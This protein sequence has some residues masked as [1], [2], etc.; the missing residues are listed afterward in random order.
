MGFKG[1]IALENSAGIGHFIGLQSEPSRSKT[2]WA[3]IEKDSI[4]ARI[5]AKLYPEANVQHSP[6]ET[7]R[8]PN[9]SVDLVIGNF[10][11]AKE[12][13]SDERYPKLSLHN[14]F[15][16][17]SLD[18]VKPG[19]IVAAITSNSTMDNA[20][21]A[22]ARQYMA[23]RADLIGAIRL[24]NNA[25]KENANTDVTTDILF[26][27]KRDGTPFEG[28]PFTRTVEGRT[29]DDEPI[30]LNEYFQKHPEMMLGKMSLEGTMYGPDQPA[31]VPIEGADLS[32]QIQEAITKLPNDAFGAQQLPGEAAPVG[33][34]PAL[35]KVGTLS[36]RGEKPG[37]IQP[38]GTSE[39]PEWA[40]KPE[41][42][43][44]AK[45]Y[46][47]IRDMTQKL[48]DKMGTTDAT[49]D[50][51]ATDR[52]ELNRLYDD[53]VSKYGRLNE[54]GS[55]FLDEDGD[56]ALALSL[57][58]GTPK[59]VEGVGKAGK[60]WARRVTDWAKSK[61][62]TQRT[63]FPRSEPTSAET[64]E[65]GYHISMNF[66]GKVD[67][68]YIAQL[69]GKT[70]E[71][72]KQ[73]LVNANLAFENATTGQWEPSWKYLSGDVRGKLAEA[74]RML[75]DNP[76]YAPNVAALEKVQPERIAFENITFRLGATYIPPEVVARFLQEKLGL[77]D[78][79]VQFTKQTGDWHIAASRGLNEAL[80]TTT[81]GIHGI[82]GSEM[83][84]L[85]LNLKNPI[86]YTT[87]R[88]ISETTGKVYD[89]EV[90]DR[91][92]T[93]QAEAKQAL[94]KD[95]FVDWAKQD[96]QA[97]KLI[98]DSYNESADIMRMPTF[99]PPTFEHYPGASEEIKL[100]D[101]QKRVVTR[102]LSDSTI[103]AHAVGTGKTYAMI[104]A[105]MEMRRLGLAKKPMIV[106]QNATLG[107]FAASFKRLYPS[108]RVLVPGERQRDAQNRQ[109]TMSRIATGD[110]DAVI[111]PQSFINMMPDD[112]QRER[113]Y[114]D[115]QI[116][117]LKEALIEEAAE[118]GGKSPKAK[119]IQR[120]IK[121]LQKQLDKLT[122]RAQDN[123]LNFDQLGVDAL[124]VDEA[125]EYK[126]NQFQTRMDKIK[127]LDTGFSQ[128]GLSMMMKLRSVQEKNQGRNTIFATGTPISNTLAE[129]WNMMRFIRPDVLEKYGIEKFDSFAANFCTA[130]TKLEMQP[131]GAW[132]PETRFALFVNGPELISA[133]RTVADVVT[134]EEINLPG[135]PALREGKIQPVN[136]PQTPNVTAYIAQIQDQLNAFK[137]M[138]GKERYEHSYIP[139]VCF[140]NAKKA[141]LD[142][143]LINPDL[144]EEPGNKLSIAADQISKI[145]KDSNDVK[146]AQ[147]VF[148][149]L[150]QNK[151]E[152]GNV[153]FNLYEEMK[154]KLIAL[155]IPENEI[156]IFS[157]KL[158]EAQ[159][160]IAIQ[161]LNDGVYRV[162]IGGTQRMGVGI[163]AQEH[164]IAL[165]HLDAPHRPMDIE[166]RNG[167]IVRQGN[168][169]P[170]VDIFSYGVEKSLDAAL[171]Q[172]L[173]RKQ[174]FTNQIM[175]GDLKGR[176]FE[177]PNNEISMSFDE[178]MAAYSGDPL[179]LEKVT[180]ENVINNLEALRNGHFQQ[181]AKGREDLDNIVRSRIPYN[182]D[183]LRE[184]RADSAR[185]KTEFADMDKVP[186]IV[187]ERRYVGR[188]EIGE[189]LTKGFE[190][191]FDWVQK[192]LRGI[193]AE[194]KKGEKGYRVPDHIKRTLVGVKFGS[195]P[196]EFEVYSNVSEFSPSGSRDGH[197]HVDPVIYWSVK[198]RGGIGGKVV[199]GNGFL[200]SFS[201]SLDHLINKVPED[202]Q[203][204]VE[205]LHR[206]KLQ[207][208]SFVQT[209][210]DREAELADAKSRYAQVMEKLTAQGQ[211]AAVQA[212]KQELTPLGF[213]V[214]RYKPLEAQRQQILNILAHI[215]RL[216][217][218]DVQLDRDEKYLVALI[219]RV[220]GIYE[221][222]E[223]PQ[224][225]KQ[226]II[227]AL[228]EK[229]DQMVQLMNPKDRVAVVRGLKDRL[230]KVEAELLKQA[231]LKAGITPPERHAL[232]P[233]A[234]AG[235][236]V[237][238]YRKG[239]DGRWRKVRPDGTLFPIPATA[240][241][242]KRLEA[243]VS[244]KGGI[245][246]DIARKAV[247]DVVGSVPKNVTF[248]TDPS[249]T[250]QAKVNL[251]SGKITLNLARIDDAK[252]AQKVFRE[253][254]IH[255]VWDHPD[256]AE[257]RSAIEKM[258]GDVAISRQLAAGYR[259]EVAPEEAANEIVQ[260]LYREHAESGIF[261]RAINQIVLAVKKF[262]GID[263]TPE[264]AALHIVNQA[265]KNTPAGQGGRFALARTPQEYEKQKTFGE[266]AVAARGVAAH[267]DVARMKADIADEMKLSPRSRNIIRE[268]L[269]AAMHA[270]AIGES[271]S[272]YNYQSARE[273]AKTQ[274][275]H[276]QW[277]VTKDA[278][279]SLGNESRYMEDV[280]KNYHQLLAKVESNA[281]TR[282]IA[283]T[284]KRERLA[285]IAAER[286][287]TFKNVIAVKVQALINELNR[288]RVQD[289][290]T[291][292]LR[293]E[294]AQ[295]RKL[296]DFSAA[297]AQKM[298]QIV[299]KVYPDYWQM[300]RSG[301]RG[302]DYFQL[303][304]AM[305]KR[306]GAPLTDPQE[307]ALASI[308]SEILGINSHLSE[309]LYWMEKTKR[310]P[311]FGPL[312]EST[313]K[314]FAERLEKDPGKAVAELMRKGV[315]LGTR[316]GEAEAAFKSLQA[317]T[318]KVLTE[319]GDYQDAAMAY[320]RM[321][322]SPEWR[323]L[324]DMVNAD[325]GGLNIP[326]SMRDEV[327]KGKINT[328][329]GHLLEK[330]PFGVV[331]DIHLG[332]TPEESAKAQ[333]QLE[334]Y[335]KQVENWLYHPDNQNDPDREFWQQKHDFID[336]VYNTNGVLSPGAV[337]SLSFG[338]KFLRKSG[339]MPE[340]FFKQAKLPALKV[341]QTVFENWHRALVVAAQWSQGTIAPLMRAVIDASKAHGMDPNLGS[342]RYRESV[343]NSLA[344]AYRHNQALKAGDKLFGRTLR[345]TDI[346][347]L[348]R[349]GR[350]MNE[351]MTKEKSIGA[352]RV[353]P[354][355]MVFDQWAANSFAIRMP[356]E[357]GAEPGTTVPR[358]ISQGAGRSMAT[359]MAKVGGN[360]TAQIE[361]LNRYFEPYVLRWLGERSA[362][363]SRETPFE[364]LFAQFV[365]KFNRGDADAKT[366]E[367]LLDFIN[368]NSD[369]EPEQ[370]NDIVVG[371]LVSE[372]L[373]MW[374]NF[375][376]PDTDNPQA[377]VRVIRAS[378]ETPFTTA[379]EKDQG[380]SFWY[381]YGMMTAA[382]VRSTA[383][384]STMYHM[385]RLDASMTA[386]ETALTEALADLR[387]VERDPMRRREFLAKQKQLWRSGDDFRDF[388][389]LESQLHELK[390]FHD[391][392]P[393]FTGHDIA[394]YE[395]LTLLNRLVRDNVVATLSGLGTMMRVFTGSVIKQG[396]V[397]SAFERF[398]ALAYPKAALNMAMSLSRLM[399]VGPAMMAGRRMG[400][401]AP[402]KDEISGWA[403]ELFRGGL[404][405]YD[406]QFAYGLGTKNPT[407]D[408]ISNNLRLPVTH[409][410]GYNS[411]L[412]ENRGLALIQKGAFQALSVAEAPL[413][414]IKTIFP[415]LGYSVAYD[416]VARQT[417]WTVK[418]LETRARRTFDTYEKLGQLGRF[419]LDNPKSVKNKLTPK[420]VLKDSLLPATE[421]QLSL[422]RE[423]FK[424]GTDIDLN[425]AIIYYWKKLRD[426]PVEQRDQVHLLSADARPGQDPQKLETDRA[427]A[428]ASIG[429]FDIHHA[430]PAN[431]AWFLR[432]NSF[433]RLAWPIAGWSLQSTRQ[434]F[435]LMGQAAADPRLRPWALT[436]MTVV[437]I[438]G[439]LGIQTLGGDLEK[440]IFSWLKWLAFNEVDPIKN[441]SQA[442]DAKEAAQI[443]I[444]DTFSYIPALENMI[445]LV[446][447]ER[448]NRKAQIESIFLVDK[449]K[450]LMNYV[451]GVVHTGDPLYGLAALTRRDMPFLRPLVNRLPGQEGLTEERN[452]R[453]VIQMFAPQEL[454]R[455]TEGGYG[456]PTPTELTPIKQAL[457]NAIYK[458][459]SE[460]VKDNYYALIAKATELG[461]KDPEKLAQ[462]IVRSLNPYS[463]ALSGHPTDEQR[464]QMLSMM[465]PRDQQV[466]KNGETNFL[467]A[468][469]MLGI[470][471][472]MTKQEKQ[473]AAPKTHASA[474]PRVSLGGGRSLPAIG[475]AHGV[476]TVGS[477]RR[478]TLGRGTRVGGLSRGRRMS[479]VR[480]RLRARVRSLP[481]SR[482]RVTL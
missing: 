146:G 247:K 293:Q 103:L 152:H 194:W 19:G 76:H 340:F 305:R 237:S 119:D 464:E 458:G 187:G 461:K 114:I 331:H 145:Y 477:R 190:G 469:Q 286:A 52:A 451:N 314:A 63:K 365:E 391:R 345:Q 401:V 204:T 100:R 244:F 343:F 333:G 472:E 297:V 393:Q 170:I 382:E 259:P 226:N 121:G 212:A 299:S 270:R 246:E 198:D 294:L 141:A 156:V 351:I 197:L 371:G 377:Q 260:S 242:S 273:W 110:W 254:L 35:G 482:R 51:I 448:S 173:A 478:V 134:P 233:A 405:F 163:N 362:D 192:E 169:N 81:Y 324:V 366:V 172:S 58:D 189:Q 312:V 88:R 283:T 445:D 290:R 157:D 280:D 38:D 412:S 45:Q 341:M 92:L 399:T 368:S 431:R 243:A 408:T 122:G 160:D 364:G 471:S 174:R 361:L 203:N 440:R 21:S 285:D 267:S 56:F 354:K 295:T 135:L 428:L 60:P 202:N 162:A 179:T 470:G 36:F 249:E 275:P 410:G 84:R 90:K 5:L 400:L 154:R 185:L 47:E 48:I 278:L 269:S 209:K 257:A 1:G 148:A 120:A 322:K 87:E 262:F 108:S 123:V 319:F 49:E 150:Y 31:L 287:E 358:E 85:A 349:N 161:K 480:G 465:S 178:Q 311:D 54:R 17:R 457:A 68:D 234:A 367:D 329:T 422:S 11:F 200:S 79:Q 86:V 291:D 159:R 6:F 167:R 132:E 419:D 40:S 42:V 239:D 403:E 71:Q 266:A 384:D 339:D 166:Q 397:L 383:V 27:R 232:A 265:L 317:K 454:I 474:L 437:G 268:P 57:E 336:A 388:E 359:S 223:M 356:Q 7:A 105:A 193:E 298:E 444:S 292:Q 272:I 309:M 201:S 67:P 46:V 32:K 369:Y 124:F 387:A 409:G 168:S 423:F 404:R 463:M 452:V 191:Q 94:V 476:R 435:A 171:F 360:Q 129:V 436:T 415:T 430:S 144:P 446:T 99:E 218:K 335:L 72:V 252:E 151:D 353:M 308:A 65:D 432:A 59:I 188:K 133:W 95:E 55:R 140:T 481:R 33:G 142:M 115:G 62:F 462:Q 456:M 337:K 414:V 378:R 284:L 418:S 398:P 131:G 78:A 116:A 8:L 139:V 389:D 217:E 165:H 424:R 219:K 363:Y 73:T 328:F 231:Q 96:P 25:F 23:E 279:H 296:T 10:P 15:F 394:K 14:Y 177:D 64:P 41:K 20:A 441:L 229:H 216:E 9:N 80:N 248:I 321:R 473:P 77:T 439:V 126:K 352:Q 376:R 245:A 138:T 372:A 429:L 215:D 147:M 117:E 282:Q 196:I 30:E 460:G 256:V 253:E 61:I 97:S 327:L 83:V 344:W 264:Q 195:M 26:F 224:D 357:F 447:N 109:R 455:Q 199:S 443:A 421:T 13:P 263:L 74:K 326:Q 225:Y 304:D 106:V 350:A 230:A 214:S 143:R 75:A 334:G 137:A 373:K 240:E 459:D 330:D 438:L 12:G 2:K 380:S 323:A 180:L 313:S 427:G 118:G 288:S 28:Q 302:Q 211:A 310:E 104:T 220:R 434:W 18:V 392:L 186:L 70:V 413:E 155:G 98:E 4:S 238:G 221:D 206:Q 475:R 416:S 44:Q 50:Q 112:P 136:V 466:L 307:R 111:I 315:A 107:Q 467:A 261:K 208:E 235:T 386:G 251:D 375:Y 127:G 182:E 222:N 274:S 236:E 325:A 255:G 205:S 348:R 281:F 411:K 289:A 346:D 181:I 207:L 390:S 102:M 395:G 43:A 69:T 258:V 379:F 374:K 250:W 468:T 227:E 381:D 342:D 213:D 277:N 453:N 82:P 241:K 320:A 306:E 425:D 153:R 184:S 37:I 130:E 355:E 228:E 34:G 402:I 271:G 3:A 93:L 303:Y 479:Y 417:Y 276:I 113:D 210:F 301:K 338:W 406:Q 396:L 164:L 442:R 16:A 128:R 39:T 66:R 449:I 175:R 433:G 332:W 24:P 101:H 347:L 420:E 176:N 125:H 89:A 91:K 370:V 426:T 407:L 450:S 183:Q 385:T 300:G 318:L 53:Y 22:K 158:S 29:H 316:A 149:D